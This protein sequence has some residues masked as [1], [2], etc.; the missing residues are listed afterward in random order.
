M[1]K[2]ESYH[3]I[4]FFEKGYWGREQ[5]I[6]RKTFNFVDN[7]VLKNYLFNVSLFRKIYRNFYD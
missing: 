7:K 3:Q 6:P 4:C 5:F 2:T 1:Y